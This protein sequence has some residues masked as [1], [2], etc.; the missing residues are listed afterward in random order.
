VG[1]ERL[2]CGVLVTFDKGRSSFFSPEL[3][4]QM[5]PQPEDIS[6]PGE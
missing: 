6:Q 5:L 2:S 3:L 4:R 1:A